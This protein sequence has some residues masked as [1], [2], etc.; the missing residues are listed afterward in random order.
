MI[1]DQRYCVDVIN[2]MEAITAALRRIQS[3][4]LRDHISAVSRTAM[5]GRLPK[6]EAQELAD[7]VAGLLKRWR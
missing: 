2:Q 7:E 3:G 4:M 6:A 1:T 5:A